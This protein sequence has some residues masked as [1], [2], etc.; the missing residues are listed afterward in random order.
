MHGARC[1]QPSVDQLRRGGSK[2][3]RSTSGS[4]APD[5]ASSVEDEKGHPFHAQLARLFVQLGHRLTLGVIVQARPRPLRVDTGPL[6]QIDQD[7]RLRQ[8]GTLQ[9]VAGNRVS[10][11][12]SCRPRCGQPDQPVRGH[13][14][15]LADDALERE[16]DADAASH[17]RSREYR[18]LGAP[19]N[20]AA[21]Y[22]LR[23]M[24]SGG[25]YGLS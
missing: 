3:P 15:R 23:S 25:S 18:F 1:A 20:F 4:C 19:P 14:V 11:I 6:R 24:P 22:S 8:V 16:V 13:R 2:A 10:T 17:G 21:T 7:T 12:S 5:T 9:K